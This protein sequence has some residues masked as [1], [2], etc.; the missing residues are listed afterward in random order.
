MKVKIAYLL[1]S[2]NFSRANGVEKVVSQL[3][4]NQAA[5]SLEV[6]VRKKGLKARL[7]GPGAEMQTFLPSIGL[8][9]LLETTSIIVK[10]G[11]LS[12]VFQT[13]SAHPNGAWRHT[14]SHKTVKGEVTP[15]GLDVIFN[16]FFTVV[17]LLK[18]RI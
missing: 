10:S 17:N 2:C 6:R 12:L 13:G 4:R 7:P 15:Y 14:S 18:K 1:H 9:W 5:H 8:G 16:L 11:L 3:A